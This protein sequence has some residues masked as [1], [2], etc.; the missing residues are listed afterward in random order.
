MRCSSNELSQIAGGSFWKD[1]VDFIEEQETDILN[2]LART[3]WNHSDGSLEMDLNT[4]LMHDEN[5][6]G[7]LRFISIMKELPSYLSQKLEAERED[8]KQG[9]EEE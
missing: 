1:V 2:E 7:A 4:R 5:L 8:E 6:R 9:K 3:S